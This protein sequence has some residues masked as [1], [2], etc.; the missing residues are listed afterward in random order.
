MDLGFTL[1][2]EAYDPAEIVEQAVR[3]EEAGFDFVEVS[4]HFH[5]WVSE[6]E[7]SGFAFSMLAAIAA[8]TSSI[9]LATGVTCPFI[10]YHPAIVAQAAATTAILSGGRFTLGVGA[11]ER[12]NEHVVGAGWPAVTTRHE[13][14]REALEII[15]LLWSGGYHSYDGK[16]LR[17][18]DARVFDL[19]DKAPEIAVA[20]GG[21]SAAEL[22]AELGDAL[23][24]TE[25]K[26]EL[27][28]AYEKAGGRG[29]K[30]AEVPLAWAPS[31]DEGAESARRLFR[32]GVT[33]WKVQAEL[34]NPVNF[35]A[36]TALVTAD[37]LREQFGCGPDVGR[38]LEV[39]RQ[40][41]DAGYDRLALI[42]D[43][44]DVDGF[45]DFF[46]KELQPE[47]RTM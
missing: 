41:M 25:P 27:I 20:A 6:H 9:R 44:P 43:G 11:G 23:F 2:A 47:L 4:D 26:A 3:A 22:A 21:E 28:S 31:E 16:H 37:H 13:M 12:L 32:F 40:Y 17:L 30:Y 5:P 35:D 24:A 29:P 15:R 46:T 45:F 18:E 10:R 33:G 38:H 8:R 19:P 14:L 1:I 7:H 39:A 36:A 42:N 34:P